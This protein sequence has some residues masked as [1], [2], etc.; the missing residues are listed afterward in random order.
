MKTTGICVL[1]TLLSVAAYGGA[2]AAIPPPQSTFTKADQ[3]E[4]P[5]ER[6]QNPKKRTPVPAPG[7]TNTYA[8]TAADLAAYLFLH[9]TR[10]EAVGGRPWT[11]MNACYEG[12]YQTAVQRTAE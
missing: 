1:S 6:P 11:R 9:E 10:H 2:I 7:P 5:R 3:R 8:G 12:D 4:L